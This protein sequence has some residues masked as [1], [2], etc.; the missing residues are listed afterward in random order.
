MEGKIEIRINKYLRTN[1][2]QPI[3]ESLCEL[4]DASLNSV[5]VKG[6]EIFHGDR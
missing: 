6:K 4:S 3:T 1:I 5:E 2:K